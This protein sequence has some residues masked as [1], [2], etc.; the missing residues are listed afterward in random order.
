MVLQKHLKRKILHRIKKLWL[1][2]LVLTIII[3]LL[4]GRFFK[5]IFSPNIII[6]NTENS[7]IYIPDSA[8]FN[9]VKNILSRNGN[10]KDIASF[11]WVANHKNYTKNIKSGRYKLKNKMSNNALINMLRNGKQ[12]PVNLTF[13]NVRTLNELAG[14]VSKKLSCDS[15]SFL[16]A[17]TND[18]LIKNTGFNNATFPLLFIPDTY[19]IYWN[20][21]PDKFIKRMKKE[22]DKFWN[23]NRI[24]KAKEQNLTPIEVGILASIVQ[25]ETNKIKEQPT[26][27]G[28]YINRL[29]KNI[30]LQADPTLKFVLNDFSIKRVLNKDKLI[31][32]PY[33]TYQ[34]F[35]LPPGPIRI[36]SKNSLKAVLNAEKHEYIFMCAKEDFSGYHNFAKTLKQH[37]QNAK[38]YQNALNKVRIK[39]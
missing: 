1:F 9:D 34:N 16:E 3:L 13:N 4:S 2:I 17:F 10:I 28:L 24:Q 21:K 38:K 30:K 18:S 15:I 25:E 27:A 39:R 31:K 26:I 20:T 8:S 22:Y 14:K 5:Y 36:P 7:H 29:N 37:N 35:G 6:T 32:S 23:S 19:F 33:N 12:D 11:E